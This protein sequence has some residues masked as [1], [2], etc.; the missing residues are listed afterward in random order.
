MT[1]KRIG[2]VGAG[3]MGTGIAQVC[4]QARLDIV[5]VDV[6][7]SQLDRALKTIAWSLNKLA[8]KGLLDESP[9]SILNRIVPSP[10]YDACAD[11]DLVVEAVFEELHAKHEVLTQLATI[12]PASTILGSNTSTIPI[13]RLAENMKAPERVI[14]IHFFGPVPLMKLVEIVPHAATRAAV[15]QRVLEFIRALGK[16][17]VLV[18]QDIPGFLMN[19]IFGVMAIEAIRLVETGAGS[20]ADIDQGMCDGFNMRVGPLAIADAAGL[21]IMLNACRVMHELDPSRIPEP[22]ALLVDLVKAGNLGAKSGQGFYRWDG[23][24]RLGSAI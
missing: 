7:E 6:R 3:F 8:E 23:V 21:D 22:P 11:A 19:R 17:P 9:K 15:T 16:N 20:V 5:L 24:K 14:G 13:T 10:T 4:A 18:K 1:L 2:V 12:C